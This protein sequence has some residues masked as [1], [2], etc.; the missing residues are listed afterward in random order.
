MAYGF[1][2]YQAHIMILR[3]NQIILIYDMV[4]SCVK[5]CPIKVVQV[6]ILNGTYRQCQSSKQALAIQ[7]IYHVQSKPL[8]GPG[9][10]HPSR[11]PPTTPKYP[12]DILSTKC[13]QTIEFSTYLEVPRCLRS[14]VETHERRK[15]IC[16]G[17]W[18]VC[19]LEIRSCAYKRYS[20]HQKPGGR[21]R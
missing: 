17:R 6:N 13:R 16:T 9:L 10:D 21:Q 5:G 7:R 14:Y 15:T 19:G 3:S 11:G 12:N 1:S 18:T 2:L 20:R 4:F 8:F